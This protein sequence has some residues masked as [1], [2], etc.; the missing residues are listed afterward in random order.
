MGVP[1]YRSYVSV[2]DY[3]MKVSVFCFCGIFASPSEG[4]TIDSVGNRIKYDYRRMDK[5]AILYELSMLDWHSLFKARL[6][7]AGRYLKSV[8]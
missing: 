2:L 7:I 4:Y 5:D 1:R 8:Y 3:R 6:A